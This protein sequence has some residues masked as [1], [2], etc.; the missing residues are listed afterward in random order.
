M[1]IKLRY[2]CDVR[3]RTRNILN[4]S[5]KIPNFSSYGFKFYYTH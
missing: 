1:R 4:E 3:R 2:D 5:I